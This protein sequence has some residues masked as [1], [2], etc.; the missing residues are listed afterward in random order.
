MRDLS[1]AYLLRP[2]TNDEEIHTA[3]RQ[4]ATSE[5]IYGGRGR[6][7]SIGVCTLLLV[8]ERQ[9]QAGAGDDVTTREVR[10]KVTWGRFTQRWRDWVVP[11][12]DV[13]GSSGPEEEVQG[14][15]RDGVPTKLVKWQY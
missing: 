15:G 11:G 14:V 7:S 1:S 13:P 8:R 4:I 12:P 2:A 3:S 10:Q 9:C 5:K 6:H